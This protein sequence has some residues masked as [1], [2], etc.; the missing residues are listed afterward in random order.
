MR[1][2]K[3]TIQGKH[4]VSCASNI[5]RKAGDNVNEEELKKTVA[6]VWYRFVELE[7]NT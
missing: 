7:E 2:I 3:L 6:R 1:K 4:C 5:E